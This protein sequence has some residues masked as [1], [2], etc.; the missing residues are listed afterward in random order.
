MASTEVESEVTKFHPTSGI[1]RKSYLVKNCWILL[2]LDMIQFQNVFCIQLNYSK[3]GELF[4]KYNF[5][6]NIFGV[7]NVCFFKK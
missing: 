4:I 3:I 5:G 6:S 1:G 7:Q 2:K